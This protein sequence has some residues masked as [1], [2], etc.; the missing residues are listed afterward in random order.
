MKIVEEATGI[1][2]QPLLA[3]I[4]SYTDGETHMDRRVQDEFRTNI[5]Q[6]LMTLPL[7]LVN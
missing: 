5:L 3:L 2:I 4:D 7:K 6:P 1:Y